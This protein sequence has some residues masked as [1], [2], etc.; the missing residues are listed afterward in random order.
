MGC[1]SS[2]NGGQQKKHDALNKKL[3]D[4][5]YGVITIN[6]K[7]EFKDTFSFIVYNTDTT[8]WKKITY[9]TDM[10][11]KCQIAPYMFNYDDYLMI[12]R[13]KTI[14]GNFY[15]VIIDEHKKT[16]KLISMRQKYLIFEG[17]PQHILKHVFAVDFSPKTN[18]LKSDTTNSAKQLPY[19][20]DQYYQPIE[21]KGYW[22]QIKDENGKKGWIKWRNSKGKLLITNYYDA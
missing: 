4:S 5:D 8:V 13:C 22:L 12:F 14:S 20:K 9:S 7:Q 6:E 1:H 10:V 11:T 21:I 2:K 17:W 16:E 18:P 3:I 19:K 15:K